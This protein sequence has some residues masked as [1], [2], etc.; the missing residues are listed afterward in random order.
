MKI[1]ENNILVH[2]CFY[3][4]GEYLLFMDTFIVK[5]YEGNEET[6]FENK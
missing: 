5:T 1:S 2:R 4:K 3:H 6:C